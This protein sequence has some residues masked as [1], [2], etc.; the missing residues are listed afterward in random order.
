[1]A[2]IRR[3]G[4]LQLGGVLGQG[5]PA[6]TGMTLALGAVV[7][8]EDQW[9]ALGDV[10]LTPRDPAHFSQVDALR[11]EDIPT[12]VAVRL[13]GVNQ[14]PVAGVVSLDPVAD[15]SEAG[16]VYTLAGLEL[17]PATDDNQDFTVVLAVESE[18]LVDAVPVAQTDEKMVTVLVAAA[19]DSP[20]L[21]V[22]PVTLHVTP[23]QSAPYSIPLAITAAAGAVGEVLTLELWNLP[24]GATLSAGT[25]SGGVWT[26]TQAQLDGLAL[27]VPEGFTSATVDI[28]ALST[29]GV[30]SAEV[31]SQ[32]NA[33]IVVGYGDALVFEVTTSTPGE[34]VTLPGVSG[35]SYSVD[36]DWGDTTQTTANSYND[37]GLTHSYATAGSYIVQLSGT[38]TAL[39]FEG[40]SAQ[41]QLT[42]VLNLGATGL[43]TMGAMFRSCSNLTTVAQNGVVNTSSVTAMN[44]AFD[45]C[46]G[47]VTVTGLG[48]LDTGGVANFLSMFNGCSAMTS[49]PDTS[50]WDLSAATDLR[51]MFYGCTNMATTPDTSNWST[52]NLTYLDYMFYNA[53][54]MPSAP[55]TSGWITSSVTSMGSLFYGCSNMATTPDTSG[56]IT[57]SVTSMDSLFS[58]CASMPSAPDTSGWSL[59]GL[60]SL[61]SLFSGCSDMATTPDTSGWNTSTITNMNSLFKGCSSM[62]SA[63]DTS[64]WNTALV[65]NMSRLF[66]SCSAMATAPDTSG[67]N[68]AGVSNFLGAFQS[69]SSMASAPDTSGWNTAG[70][71]DL[72]YMFFGCSSMTSAPDLSGWDVTSVL[73]ADWFLKSTPGLTTPA[74]DA[75]LLAWSGQALQSGVSVDFGASNY[76]SGGAAETARTAMINDDAWTITDGGAA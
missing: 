67:W 12:G 66:E 59:A 57:S 23:G 4:R 2:M 15:L 49:A 43:T 13:N 35:H 32:F 28:Q 8:V 39:L 10:T 11:L 44:H 17:L 18:T 73:Y 3:L 29:D 58:G 50:N 14:T 7:G 33:A 25:E 75:L 47:L 20:S 5:L 6:P 72:R 71:S 54:S 9:V 37:A 51:Y 24:A 52:G 38:A 21:S 42:K 76:T 31:A 30:D 61:A 65:G 48:D 64:G 70:V 27:V 69:C 41:N 68:T 53:S 1:M 60:S 62:P 56:W 63:P 74:Y 46:S 26:V 55:D 22:Q 45:G 16:G 34:S 36:V 19:A 40:S